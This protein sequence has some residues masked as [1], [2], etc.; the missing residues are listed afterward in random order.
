MTDPLLHLSLS[1]FLIFVA[2]LMPQAGRN[3]PLWL[4]AVWSIAI[5]AALTLL[6]KQILG[7]PL[8]PN[9]DTAHPGAQ[10][11]EKLIEA[12]WWLMGARGAIGLMRL[13][14]ILEDRPRETQIISDL[15]AGTIY[16]SAALAIINFVF[17]VPIGGRA[18]TSGR[19][20]M[21]LCE[22][23]EDETVAG[24]ATA[25]GVEPASDGVALFVCDQAR[26]GEKKIAAIP[27]NR[28]I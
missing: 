28:V 13:V 20:P 22:V 2:A 4:R 12:G 16:I 27:N 23:P 14:V 21:G 24:E 26:Q 5:F 15:V 3:R 7:S 11:W 10:F 1:T 19:P 17:A 25:G 8:R 9:F 6:L 18:G